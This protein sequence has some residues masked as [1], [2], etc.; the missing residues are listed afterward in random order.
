[1]APSDIIFRALCAA[2]ESSDDGVPI[3]VSVYRYCAASQGQPQQSTWAYT[4][5]VEA[6]TAIA[7]VRD[8]MTVRAWWSKQDALDVLESARPPVWDT[9]EN[10]HRDRILCAAWLHLTGTMPQVDRC[11]APSV[12]HRTVEGWLKW[13]EPQ[14]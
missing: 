8:A 14:C 12:R 2:V 11:L 10:R 9:T 13:W 5:T 3:L 6:V 4:N 1:M 7:G